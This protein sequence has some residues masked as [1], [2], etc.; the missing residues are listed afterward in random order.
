[1]IK[2][3]Q[4]LSLKN[5]QEA[6]IMNPALSQTTEF[7]ILS[8][9]ALITPLILKHPQILVGIIINMALIRGALSLKRQQLIP[10]II[11]PSIGVVL[12]GML[13]GSLTS[14]L[15]Y[16]MPAIWCGN[17]LLI[18]TFKIRKNKNYFSSLI[19][20]SLL[21]TTF[22][23]LSAFLMYKLNLIPRGLLL[24]MGYIQFITAILGGLLVFSEL[25]IEKWVLTR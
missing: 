5:W 25:K 1:M 12:G 7:T 14:F 21:K 22:I 2:I 17:F 23:F 10:L 3:K 4:Y 6:K 15:F 24:A 13:F 11:F 9:L 18:H 19:L 16:L 20:A 8:I